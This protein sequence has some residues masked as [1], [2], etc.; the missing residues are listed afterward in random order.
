[1]QVYM[2]KYDGTHGVFKGNVSY[3]GGKIVVDGHKTSVHEWYEKVIYYAIY[4]IQE[5]CAI[6]K[7]P[8]DA[9]YI[10]LP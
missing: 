2:F 10:S 5:S 8:R 7:P 4:I 9:P 3:E 6:A 1:M